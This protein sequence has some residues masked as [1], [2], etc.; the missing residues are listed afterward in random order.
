MEE[1]D[2][3]KDNT[4]SLPVVPPDR[5]QNPRKQT[6]K[7]LVGRNISLPE[8]SS[9]LPRLPSFLPVL[10][11]K[12]D[13][14]MR[15]HRICQKYPMDSRLSNY[16]DEKEIILNSYLEEEAA[17]EATSRSFGSLSASRITLRNQRRHS[18]SRTP[19]ASMAVQFI[20]PNNG[21]LPLLNSRSSE[22]DHVYHL[23]SN[24]TSLS[25]HSRRVEDKVIEHNFRPRK[26][27]KVKLKVE[28]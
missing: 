26:S 21:R 23:D 7:V 15:S 25:S 16:R 22:Q 6:K 8:D 17:R 4:D 1:T 3:T 5:R 2:S 24:R 28:T 10:G 11:F 13:M 12:V 19:R 20:S 18:F 9:N 27:R 14:Q